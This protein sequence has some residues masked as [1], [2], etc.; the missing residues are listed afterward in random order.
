MKWTCERCGLQVDDKRVP[1]DC[2][3]VKG[4]KHEWEE[5]WWAEKKQED[6]KWQN[7]LNSSDGI[8]WQN[9]YKTIKTTLNESVESLQKDYLKALE[10]GK[11]KHDQLLKLKKE[12]KIEVKEKEDRIRY[13]LSITGQR[14]LRAFFIIALVGFLF[15][16]FILKNLVFGIVFAV[17]TYVVGRIFKYFKSYYKLN[18]SDILTRH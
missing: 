10:M 7:W 11:E 5:T 12:Q 14:T 9:G 1:N 6:L 13:N 18:D 15:I 17:F 2:N 16:T 8:E 3:G 4:Q